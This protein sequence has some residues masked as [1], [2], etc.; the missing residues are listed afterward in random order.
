[1]GF[2]FAFIALISWGV[3]DFLIQK[4]TRR[5]GDW[6]TLFFIDL[7]AFIGLLPF[8]WKDLPALSQ[9][10]S[11]LISLTLISLLFVV[12]A[13]LD[14]EALKRG[15]IAVIE[16]V[17]AFEIIVTTTLGTF[18]A[19]EVLSGSQFVFIA[20]VVFGI[21]LVATR[22]LSHIK[23]IRAEKGVFLAL[24]AM[25]A[26]GATNFF[27][28]VGARSVGPL[29]INWFT[30]AFSVV[31]TSVYISAKSRWPE[32]NS[33]WRRGKVIISA[34]SLF[35][36]LA[37]FAFSMATLYVPIAIATGISE[38]YIALAAM[39]GIFFT[40]EKLRI[41]QKLGLVVV[42]ASVIILAIISE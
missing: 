17:N 6:A 3:G 14:F 32:I 5:F 25:V 21:I 27:F 30:S 38:S 15:K 28:G 29:M 42:L 1:M 8:V 35:D 24:I 36:N 31:F 39:L 37:W 12:A 2:L 9:N 23:N 13:L 11:A 16:P 18:V 26:M 41:H 40:R 19:N 34:V 33:D 4:E 7:F 10:P 22:S 20:L